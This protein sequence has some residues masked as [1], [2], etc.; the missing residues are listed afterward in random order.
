MSLN[1]NLQTVNVIS[2]ETIECDKARSDS[3]CT[4]ILNATVPG[5]SIFS[6]GYGSVYGEKTRAEATQTLLCGGAYGC[7]G[8]GQMIGL[9]H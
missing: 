1:T 3:D 9:E 7:S 2:R 6:K 8:I 4:G 5:G